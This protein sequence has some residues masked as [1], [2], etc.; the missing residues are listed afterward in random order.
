LCAT[1]YK[2]SEP[3]CEFVIS[4]HNIGL[5]NYDEVVM[6]GATKNNSNF[7]LDDSKISYWWTMSPNGMNSSSSGANGFGG[8]VI[9]YVRPSGSLAADWNVN[10]VLPEYTAFLLRPVINLKPNV[11]F[12]G[13][14]TSADPY[15]VQ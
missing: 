6:A 8:A 5:L 13:T 1:F 10:S 9:W 4:F 2:R 11:T 7:Y 15:A 12:T 3:V 14:G